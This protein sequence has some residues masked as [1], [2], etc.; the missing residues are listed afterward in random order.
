MRSALCRVERVVT[1]HTSGAEP[2]SFALDRKE[3]G[4]WIF[5]PLANLVR[6]FALVNP[7]EDH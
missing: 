6:K 7:Q 5:R 3:S 2:D 1:R 4:T